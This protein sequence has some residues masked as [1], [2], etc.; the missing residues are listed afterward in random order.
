MRSLVRLTAS[1]GLAIGLVG[2]A[3]VATASPTFTPDTA[4]SALMKLLEGERSAHGLPS[5]AVD[6]FLVDVARD[7]PVPC[8]DGQVASGRAKD[9]AVHDYFS[10]QLRLCPSKDVGYAFDAWGYGGAVG[11]V[12]AMNDGYDFNTFPYQYGCD[13]HQTNCDGGDT[14][15]PTTVAIAAY[16][17]M[18]S[19]GHRDV[20][21]SKSFTRFGCGAWQTSHGAFYACL[22]ADGP[23]KA[24]ATPTPKPTAT[25][26][27]KP[28]AAPIAAPTPSM[29][30]TATPTPTASP[31]PKA[32][33]KPSPT[34]QPIRCRS[35]AQKWNGA[36][37]P[38][39]WP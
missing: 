34:A 24:A 22:Y 6:P 12:I 8:P 38:W 32:T 26:T 13:L 28:T 16:Q 27:P 2:A 18:T 29:S 11:E 7:G 35:V 31:R 39:C 20:V 25:P 37:G 4:A 9:M 21:L 1:L 33:P 30:P 36:A 23:R 17:F 10:H 14:T 3:P 5:L 15:A 19:Q